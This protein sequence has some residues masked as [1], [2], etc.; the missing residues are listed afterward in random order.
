MI[1]STMSRDV[2]C[3][4][5]SQV[6]TFNFVDEYGNRQYSPPLLYATPCAEIYLKALKAVREIDSPRQRSTVI[7]DEV[8]RVQRINHSL[9]LPK[10]TTACKC[11]KSQMR[12]ANGIAK[13]EI[14]MAEIC[15]MIH[16][17]DTH[18]IK[19]K[20]HNNILKICKASERH[21]NSDNAL[22]QRKKM[23][24]NKKKNM[25]IVILDSTASC[26][27]CNEKIE[28]IAETETLCCDDC[29]QC[30]C[31]TCFLSYINA[32]KNATFDPCANAS[33]FK[34]ATRAEASDSLLTAL[35]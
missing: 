3:E 33:E 25:R 31:S 27:A 21:H 20:F 18:E 17:L 10:K 22:V 30:I 14:V 19:L 28:H 1:S 4:N 6:F 16:N 12:V 8:A 23:S 32:A 13:E 2:I 24:E 9:F 11:T 34:T 7:R 29:K 35:H 15:R 5:C 26:I